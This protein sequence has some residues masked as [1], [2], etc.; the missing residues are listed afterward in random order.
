MNEMK[1]ATRGLLL[2]TIFLTIV[3]FISKTLL[4]SSSE[5]I[6]PEILVQLDP[7]LRFEPNLWLNI[8]LILLLIALFYE[9]VTWKTLRELVE[10]TKPEKPKPSQ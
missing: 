5:L 2:L 6:S 3:H 1:A 7:F 4:Y 9:V 8:S 10:P